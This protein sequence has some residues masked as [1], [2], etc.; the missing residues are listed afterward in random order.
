MNQTIKKAISDRSRLK[1]KAN[2]TGNENDILEYDILKYKKQRNYVTSLNWKTQKSYFKN[3]NQ[4]EVQSSKSFFKTFK[5]YFSNKYTHA[6]KLL[7][8]YV[9]KHCTFIVDFVIESEINYFVV[10]YFVS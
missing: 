7:L 9:A 2:K 5:P 1:N 6:E 10:R 3:L 4:N 8:K